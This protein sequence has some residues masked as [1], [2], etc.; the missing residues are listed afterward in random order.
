MRLYYTDVQDW[1][2]PDARLRAQIESLCSPGRV[3]RARAMPRQSDALAVLAAGLLLR[4]ALGCTDDA[5]LRDANGK[6][7][8]SAGPAFSLTH[9]GTLA[10]ILVAD[11]PCGVDAEPLNRA[12]RQPGR[13]FLPQELATGLSPAAL[14]TRKEAVFKADGR[15]ASL[16]RTGID[17]SGRT[18]QCGGRTFALTTHL[19]CGHALSTAAI[20][21]GGALPL[22]LPLTELLESRGVR[23]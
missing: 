6:P 8:L 17:I 7:Y 12:V 11:G 19:V 23:L 5:L 10:A 21:S 9:G 1:P 15:G 4:R 20:E 22:A 14:W 18:V 3:H 2:A 13:L 16:F